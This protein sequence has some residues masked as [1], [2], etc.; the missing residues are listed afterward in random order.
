MITIGYSTRESKPE[1]QEYLKKSCGHPKVQI[2]E[3]VNNGEKNLSQ[4]YNEIIKESIYDIVVLCHD[5]IYFDTNNWANKLVKTFSKNPEFAILGMAGT[6]HMPKSGMWWEDRSKMWGIVNHE[7]NGK[8]WESRY[9]DSLQNNIKE[10]VVVDGVLMTINKSKISKLFDESVPGFHMYDINFCFNNFLEGVKIGVFTNVRITHKSIGETN[11]SWEI[12]RKTFAKKYSDVLPA[13]IPFNINDEL[14]LT[15]SKKITNN[16]I[17]K[18]KSE[19]ISYFD[20]ENFPGYKLGDGRFTISSNQGVIKSVVGQYYKVSEYKTNL[21]LCSDFNDVRISDMLYPEYKK[22]YINN[23]IPKFISHYPSLIGNLKSDEINENFKQEII[24]L[25]NSFDKKNKQKIKI[26][27]GFSDKGG[28]TTAFINLT[29]YLNEN[30]YDCTF[31]GPHPWHL[32]KCKSNLINYLNLFE[33]DIVICHFLDLKE[34]PKVKKVILSCHEKNLYV[35]SDKFKF[36]DTAVFINDSHR[37][38][39]KKYV[40]DYKI[41]PNLKEELFSVDKPEK[42][43]IAGIIGSIDTNKQTHLSI[44]RAI[45]DKCETIYIFGNVT[46]TVYY[47]SYVKNLIG[48]NVVFYGHHSNKQEMYNMIGRVYH[49][50][51]S[52]VACLVKD[53]CFLTNTKF[54]GTESTN[55]EVSVLTNDEV[56]NKWI[57]LFNS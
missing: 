29:N 26:L 52:E 44:Q 43:K 28:S 12:N 19:K 40:G 5:D 34:R 17:S 22:L 41:I 56:I 51:I 13:K 4:V 11:Q 27:S 36:W 46:D 7:H 2:I 57:E 21:I 53:E 10:V 18:I 16:I 1:F 54:F 24:N 32:D 39:H 49:S 25:L 35:V 8:K 42:D 14:S 33:D 50:S 20:L 6:T 55:P 30:G 48:N 31:Y 45:N 47:E 3:K 37:E 38:Y 9:S 15:I 23:N